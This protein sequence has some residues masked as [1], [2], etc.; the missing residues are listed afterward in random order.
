[1]TLHMLSSCCSDKIEDMRSTL[2]HHDGLIVLGDA[3]Y[4]L[5]QLEQLSLSSLYVRGKDL[6]QRGLTPQPVKAQLIDDMLWI[7]LTNKYTNIV[8]W[9][10]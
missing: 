9:H 3:V 4:K 7:D 10:D 5:Q 2:S 1:M 8:H 6:T